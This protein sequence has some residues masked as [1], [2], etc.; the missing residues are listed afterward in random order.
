[1]F[2]ALREISRSRVRFT[3][4]SGAVGLLVFLIT[5]QQALFAGLITSFIG[6]VEN[7]NASVIVLNE[8]ARRN[9]EGSFLFPEQVDAVAA[10]DG[11]AASGAIGENTFT[12]FVERDGERVDEDAVLFGY[13]LGGLG[14]PTSLVRGRLP[15]GPNEAVAS[16]RNTADGFALGAVVEIAGE[17]G[18][19]IEIVGLGRDLQWSVAPTLFVSSDTFA[20]AQRA[21]NPD[22]GIVLAS[23]VGVQPEPGTDAAALAERITREV[24]GVEALTREQ[25]VRENPGVQ[26]VSSSANVILGLAFLVVTLVVAFFFLILT[27]QNTMTATLL[28]AIGAR[29][30]YLVRALVIQILLVMAAGVVIGV[31][32]TSAVEALARSSVPT[33][34]EPGTV[35]T[36]VG[37]LAVLALAGGLV[38]IRRTLRIDPLRATINTGRT[39]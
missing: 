27:R 36:T 13:D 22:A 4:L 29:P 24:S 11:V 31:A 20:A 18:P 26:G 17:D 30:S 8:Q 9:V 6:A 39:L 12:V 32:L 25:A 1:M 19:R 21:V 10:V 14:E 15:S 2:I 33:E 37:T 23:I 5:F 16:E 7:Q 35:V 3:L 28:R 34:L 38:S